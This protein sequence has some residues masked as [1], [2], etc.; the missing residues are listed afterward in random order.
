MPAIKIVYLVLF[1]LFRAVQAQVNGPNGTTATAAPTNMTPLTTASPVIT[2]TTVST[3]K[4][5]PQPNCG[6]RG[7]NNG[8]RRTILHHHNELRG[9]LAR[10]QT[11]VSNGWGIAPPATIMYRLAIATWWSQLARFGMRS[12]MMFHQSEFKRGARNVL[13][14]A[15][16]AW[17]STQRV[18]CAARNCGSYYAVSCMYSPG[19]A[20]VNEHVY[21]VGAVCSD[22][23]GGQCDGQA[24]CRW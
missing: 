2:T 7:L 23:H 22:C 14:W 18:G 12:N 15:K 13:N 19:G 4:P 8:L 9:S 21:R 24:L 16:M 6:N 10:G 20:I 1:A 17:W 3:R 5:W 11:Q